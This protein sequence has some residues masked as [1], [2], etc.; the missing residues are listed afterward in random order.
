MPHRRLTINFQRSVSAKT[1][2]VMEVSITPLSDPSAPNL[3]T[4][5]VGG[6][7]VQSVLLAND[8]NPVVFDLIPTDS[9]ELTERVP[10]RIA[11][12]EKYMGAMT[13]KDF[14]M[15][16][17]DVDF[18]DLDNLGNIIGGETYLQ[19][20]DR[21]RP[22]GV[23]GLDAQGHVIDAEGHVVTGDAAA[24]IVQD[25]LDEEILA[26]QQG[27]QDVQNL[28]YGALSDQYTAVLAQITSRI[29]A[30]VTPLQNADLAEKG[31]REYAVN[32]LNT[33]LDA[34]RVTTN[35]SITAIQNALDGHATALGNKADLVDGKVPLS[36]IPEIQLGKA[37]PA[38]D[39]AAM[40]A[41]AAKPGDFAVRPDGVWFLNAKPATTLSNWVRFQVAATVF[42]VNG[43]VGAVELAAA[44]VGARPADDPVPLADV[45]GLVTALG[46]KAS[47][48]SVASLTTRVSDIENDTTLVRTTG[49][50]IPKSLTPDDGAFINSAGLITRKD[51][52]VVGSGTAIDDI[53]G[54]VAALDSKAAQTDLDTLSITVGTKVD[55]LAFDNLADDVAAKASQLA[56]EDLDTT[57][58][59][60]AD[61]ATV[62]ALSATVNTKADQSA[63]S[64][65]SSA[66]AD[67]A[68]LVDGVVPLEQLPDYPAARVT[69]LLA[70]LTDKADLVDGAVPVEQLPD[71]EIE[72]VIGLQSA[73]TDKADL[74][75][76][77]VPSSQI[78]S[79]AINDTFV[80]D[81]RAELLALTA[82]EAQPG[83]LGIITATEDKG[84]YILR[85]VNPGVFASWVLMPLPDGV[86]T[87]V[88]GSNGV[89][90]LG[91]ADVGARPAADPIPLNDVTGLTA[92]LNAKA[93]TTALTTGL[94]A[95][96]SLADVQALMTVS[97]PNKLKARLVATAN[98][99]SLSGMQSIG[100]VIT[101][102]EDTVLLTA[103]N[104]SV[105]NGLYK[106]KAGA[107]ERVT[108]MAAGSSFLR[109]ALVVVSASDI[110]ETLWQQT[111][112]T[113]TV[114][115]DPNNWVRVLTGGSPVA[116]TALADG[117]LTRSGDAASG[118][119]FAAKIKA[120]GGLGLDSDGIFVDLTAT[121]PV[122]RKYSADV[123][124]SAT[125]VV[126]ITHG[127]NTTDVVASF[128][129]KLTGDAVLLGW[130]PISAAAI[131][132]EFDSPPG[133]NDWRVV[134][135]G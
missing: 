112:A 71:R 132:A 131:T 36:Q 95:K 82:A 48:G 97:T 108:D 22:G 26:R 83:D 45:T 16:D 100:G 60:K 35:S 1:P 75:D 11:W 101:V 86:V 15:P 63:L 27:D 79:I 6:T 61:Q 74:V 88:N 40:L 67:K 42:S 18:D 122:T 28:L 54:L 55:Q 120:S 110:T 20:T 84:T 24:A 126:T 46:G 106:V 85:G 17:F 133:S 5:L 41:L 121:R 116:Y 94:A 81:S 50:L 38:A 93:S 125:N 12:R 58:G 70:Q 44:D 78:P 30:A 69:G 64:A 31:Q 34:L 92:A 13:V 96:P 118:Y 37:Y 77:K 123:P 2:A 105:N 66:L 103:Q 91:A 52:T 53:T 117:G 19:W 23:A 135:V 25:G 21:L 90:V 43:Q 7:Q 68:D 102:A 73:L 32:Q 127:L 114:A 89:V 8:V 119:K 29:A 115:T 80:V 59:T 65:V 129:H 111:S 72:N 113:G 134:V 62:S 87:S 49:G 9:P 33:A 128:R 4:T 104:N 51:G 14:V 109:G 124:S 98:V 10:Y 57:V 56:L 99:V 39:E 76:G 47:T 130:K 3:N 107:W